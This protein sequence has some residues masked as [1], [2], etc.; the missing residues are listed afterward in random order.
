LTAFADYFSL[1]DRNR[2]SF[3]LNPQKDAAIYVD[4]DGNL[5]ELDKRLK[6]E[7]V[8]KFV[9][10]GDFG[11][12]KSHILRR[13]QG[14]G[15]SND[16]EPIYIELSGFGRRSDFLSVHRQIM[17]GLLPELVK[18]LIQLKEDD[19]EQV[20]QARDLMQDIKTAFKVLARKSIGR[21]EPKDVARSW[22]LAG[23]SLSPAAIRK[24]GYPD[25][26]SVLAGPVNLVTMYKAIGDLFERA[27][28][29]K[30]LILLDESESFT[31]VVDRDAQAQI[32]SGLRGFFDPENDSVGIVLGL[33]TPRA[34]S[35]THPMLRSD[36]RSR[37]GTR[38]I[39]LKPLGEPQ[40]IQSFIE[41][42]WPQLTGDSTT[43]P[44]L[45]DRSAQDVLTNN[46]DELKS[47]L[48]FDR[49]APSSTPRDVLELLS[50]IGR[51]AVNQRT[52][53]PISAPHLNRWF[54]LEVA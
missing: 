32:G 41:K 17:N 52:Q 26:L 50:E 42:L 7:G 34:R 5:G 53:P 11:T 19:I 38:R 10:E 13:I 22:L 2:D 44:F 48:I 49:L 9:V 35:G 30:L 15:C 31:Q 51:H 20:A 1:K 3:R 37:V 29:R 47:L 33:N 24:A 16:Q 6:D 45:L 39:E 18:S 4:L 12:G 23:H 14:Q 28:D 36:V 54:A 8:P 46:L 27:F 43:L 40:R 21:S 25:R